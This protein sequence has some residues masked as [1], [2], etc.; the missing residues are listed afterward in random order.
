MTDPIPKHLSDREQWSP[1]DFFQFA[2]TGEEPINPEYTKR[3]N[4]VLVEAGLEPE[5]MEPTPIEDMTP[6]Q[7]EARK[8]DQ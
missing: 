7:H 1:D 6:A 4:E 8:R 3:R 5:A 2:K